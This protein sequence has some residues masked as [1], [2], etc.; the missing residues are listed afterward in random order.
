[1]VELNQS[2]LAEIGGGETA[3]T[4]REIAEGIMV[5]GIVTGDPLAFLLGV[6]YAMSN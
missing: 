2:E 5:F 3:D 4:K 1:M 6:A